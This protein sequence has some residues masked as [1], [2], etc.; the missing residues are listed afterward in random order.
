MP[1]HYKGACGPLICGLELS[2]VIILETKY[3]HVEHTTV[4]VSE[5]REFPPFLGRHTLGEA[6]ST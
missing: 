3:G 6:E 5:K 1:R 2:L 4:I